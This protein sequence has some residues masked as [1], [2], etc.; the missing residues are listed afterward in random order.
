MVLEEK[1]G[2]DLFTLKVFYSC[3]L[4]GQLKYLVS[5]LIIFQWCDYIGH[6]FDLME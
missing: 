5:D 1:S 3:I 2:L 6:E 4:D